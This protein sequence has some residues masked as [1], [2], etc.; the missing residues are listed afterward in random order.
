MVQTY[1]K[2]NGW[3]TW[4]CRGDAPSPD[5][6]SAQWIHLEQIKRSKK[7]RETTPPQVIIKCLLI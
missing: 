2:H 1:I 6:H 7:G 5:R 4:W 3:G